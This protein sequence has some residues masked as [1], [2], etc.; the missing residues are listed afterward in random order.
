M[1]YNLYGWNAFGKHSWK[2]HN[3]I[4]KMKH[5]APD[6]MGCQE[7]KDAGRIKRDTVDPNTG[8]FEEAVAAEGHSIFYR[9]QVFTVHGTGTFKLNEK[10]KWGQRKVAWAKL[11]H[12]ASGR[13]ILHFNTHWCVCNQHDLFKTAQTTAANI[14]HIRAQHGNLPMLLTGDLN[15]FGGCHNSKAIR[16]LKGHRVDGKVSPVV[17]ADMHEGKGAP[18]GTARST[19]CSPA[20]RTGTC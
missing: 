6:L 5:Y 8:A 15:V 9:K 18:T 14:A 1:S 20:Q 4:N 13:Q 16:Y 10:D 12:R 19:T 11:Q 7:V 3:V 2:S 17:F